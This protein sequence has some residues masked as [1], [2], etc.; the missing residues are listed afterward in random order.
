MAQRLLRRR[1]RHDPESHRATF[2]DEHIEVVAVSDGAAAV[3]RLNAEPFDIV[4]ADA[5]MP[6]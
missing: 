5:G 6:A 4:L 2:A 1:Q 3:A